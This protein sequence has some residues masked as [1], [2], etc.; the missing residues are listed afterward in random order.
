MKDFAKMTD[1][2][3]K[4]ILVSSQIKT[5]SQ[6][7]K[8]DIVHISS[9]RY[10]YAVASNCYKPVV[11]TMHNRMKKPNFQLLKD[12]GAVMVALTE[13]YKDEIGADEFVHLGLPMKEIKPNFEKGKGLVVVGRITDQKGI[14]IAI[15]IAEKAGKK[16]TIF[17]R[18][19]NS[20]ERRSYFEEHVKPHLKEGA[21]ELAGEVSNA[22]LMKIIAGSE[23][24]LFPIIRPETFGRV[25][26]EALACGTP[27]I[28]K[29]VGPLPEILKNEKVAF[30][31]DDIE[32]LVDA[33]KSTERFDRKEC[34]KYAEEYFDIRMVAEKYLDL[35]EKIL[36][37]EKSK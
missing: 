3:K 30:L 21:I 14:H 22:D 25:S 17:G 32:E 24:L 10:S 2:Q 11:V 4:N 18:I 5:L 1:F 33:A 13:G 6:Q 26:I 37:V 16:L 15:E 23:A 20:E 35:Y 29:K 34:R 36:S 28:G 7:Q 31:S 19:G 27:I 8:F 12:A 9:Q